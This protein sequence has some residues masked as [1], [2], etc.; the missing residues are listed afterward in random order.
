[1]PK[2]RPQQ[3]KQNH[4]GQWQ[5]ISC[6]NTGTLLQKADPYDLMYKYPGQSEEGTMHGVGSHDKKGMHCLSRWTEN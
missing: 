3:Q 2:G 1:M 5:E 6:K 4:K